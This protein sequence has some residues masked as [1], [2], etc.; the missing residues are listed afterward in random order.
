[1]L[2]CLYSPPYLNASTF[3]A[4]RSINH[5]EFCHCNDWCQGTDIEAER[6]GVA[7]FARDDVKQKPK[8]VK[9]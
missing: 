5:P 7:R 6:P 1:M 4:C 9:V 8:A 3:D 2:P